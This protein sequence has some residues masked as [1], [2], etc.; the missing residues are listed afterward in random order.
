MKK[1]KADGHGSSGI[2]SLMICSHYIS[3]FEYEEESKQRKTQ[4][5]L[6]ITLRILF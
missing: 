4:V 2:F 1:K 3:G 5:A 6:G